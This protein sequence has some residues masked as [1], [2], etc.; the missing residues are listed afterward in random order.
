MW[1]LL[2][3]T[4]GGPGLICKELCN[5]FC[6]LTEQAVTQTASSRLRNWG[7]KARRKVQ[8]KGVVMPKLSPVTF[9]S[10]VFILQTSPLSVK[11]CPLA[12]CMCLLVLLRLLAST[13][14]DRSPPWFCACVLLLQ[15]SWKLSESKKHDYSLMCPHYLIHHRKWW[16]HHLF[17]SSLSRRR[18]PPV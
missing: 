4:S 2:P 7:K 16:L 10:T 8:S 5:Q 17:Y 6:R 14:Y 3:H 12:P 13:L 1:L 11:A 15:L 18:V 9:L